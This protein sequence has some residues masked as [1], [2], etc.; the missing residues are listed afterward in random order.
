VANTEKNFE[1]GTE[2]RAR[3]PLPN[4]SVARLRFELRY[5]FSSSSAFNLDTAK[6]MVSHFQSPQTRARAIGGN[7]TL[8]VDHRNATLTGCVAETLDRLIRRVDRRIKRSRRI[9]ITE[10]VLHIDQEQRRAVPEANPLAH[11]LLLVNGVC[12]GHPSFSRGDRILPGG[13]QILF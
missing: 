1:I 4:Y 11:P 7:K 5:Y 9:W 10:I 13:G 3:P 6:F 2:K 12:R 8:R